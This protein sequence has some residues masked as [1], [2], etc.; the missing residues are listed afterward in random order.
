[1]LSFVVSIVILFQSSSLPSK[2]TFSND[3]QFANASY[4]IFVT[5][6]GIT[7]SFNDVQPLN[8]N[9]EIDLAVTGKAKLSNDVQLLKPYL[10]IVKFS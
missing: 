4:P 10:P 3:V 1:M 2:Y 6:A 7:T 9:A 5:D 8:K